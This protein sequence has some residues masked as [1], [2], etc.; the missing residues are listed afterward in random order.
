MREAILARVLP[1]LDRASA[2][3]AACA[4]RPWTAGAQ[5][6]DCTRLAPAAPGR[7]AP[8][9]A[10]SARCG[11]PGEEPAAR[12][13]S[14]AGL[15]CKGVGSEGTDRPP[16]S[17]SPRGLHLQ[18]RTRAGERGGARPAV[19]GARRGV[20]RGGAPGRASGRTLAGSSQA[21]CPSR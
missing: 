5:P 17:G 12:R 13:C 20:R 18:R 21:G 11:R 19:G 2:T 7:P 15:G 4:P 3:V 1:K 16:R 6:G 9:H 10:Q 8:E 14:R